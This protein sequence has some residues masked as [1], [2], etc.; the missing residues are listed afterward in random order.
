VQHVAQ[1]RLLGVQPERARRTN[2]TDF[3]VSG[4]GRRRDALR[5]GARRGQPEGGGRLIADPL[6]WAVVVVLVTKPIEAGL[7]RLKTPADTTNMALTPTSTDAAAT[8]SS[9]YGNHVQ[10][11][12]GS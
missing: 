6:V 1:E 8:A 9:T 5:I 10:N 12:C 11:T 2:A 3:H 7:L 4:I